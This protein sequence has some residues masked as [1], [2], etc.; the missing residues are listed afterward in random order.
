M[1]ILL[2]ALGIPILVGSHGVKEF[3]V[4]YDNVGALGNQRTFED[5]NTFMFSQNGN[6][7]SGTVTIPVTSTMKQPVY[8]YYQLSK[9]YQN[10]KRYVRSRDDKQ[11]AGVGKQAN[12]TAS[13]RGICNPEEFLGGP[14]GHFEAN[15]PNGNI[16]RPCGLI[17]WSNFNDTFSLPPQ[18]N[19]R[20]D[21]IAW[22]YDIEHLYA[23]FTEENYNP[24]TAPQYRGGGNF[25]QG[26][27]MRDN[28]HL[29]VWLRPSA[30]R[31]FRKLYGVIHQDISPGNITVTVNSRYNTYGF[32]G[33][34]A[35]VLAT[36]SWVGGKNDF[37]GIMYIIFGVLALVVALGFLLTYQMGLM[38]RRR[39]GDPSYLSWNRHAN[40]MAR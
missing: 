28:Q 27:G 29:I 21:E 1:G 24:S 19:V 23:N 20:E 40:L 38:K 33:Q 9:Y 13:N 25:S 37:L 39:F 22:E 14:D 5:K 10:H 15:A 3:T 32:G 12:D 18:Y 6:G 34:K 2:L 30:H 4:N 17:A 36:T 31:T 26:P 7:A 8:L 16:A 11:L 35:I